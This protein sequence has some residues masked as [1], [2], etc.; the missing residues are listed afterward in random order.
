MKNT[1]PLAHDHAVFNLNDGGTVVLNDP[2]RFGFLLHY[3]D[4]RWQNEE[5]FASMGP[6][7]LGNDFNAPAL[8]AR[9]AGRKS[10]IKTALLDQKIV[11]GLGNI[12]VCEAL[13]QARI[14]PLRPANALK[15]TQIENL[16]VQIR[17]VLTR[18]IEAGGSSLRDYRHTDGGLGCFQHRFS[19]YDREGEICPACAG[20]CTITRIV[21]AGRSTFYCPQ[22]QK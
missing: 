13:W 21:Q 10:P 8:A 1:P 9:L 20:S 7:P 19:V 3:K 2:R 11:A 15:D 16:S 18:A 22:A 17:D 5:P 6:E 14:S 12:Y 4:D